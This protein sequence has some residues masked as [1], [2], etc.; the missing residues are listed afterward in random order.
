[1]NAAASRN[2][3]CRPKCG[4]IIRLNGNG[5]VSTMGIFSSDE[6]QDR[7][8]TEMDLEPRATP[9]PAMPEGMTEIERELFQDLRSASDEICDH[10]GVDRDGMISDWALFKVVAMLPTTQSDYDRFPDVFRGDLAFDFKDLIAK[11][12]TKRDMRAA[13]YRAKR[14][15]QD[16]KIEER[17]RKAQEIMQ[18]ENLFRYLRSLPQTGHRQ[19]DIP[20]E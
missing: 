14:L 18:E 6:E 1:M 12:I 4:A 16:A 13:A 3:L 10:V 11:A 2:K 20:D 15:E 19:P 8:V 7:D 5:V 17:F 9:L